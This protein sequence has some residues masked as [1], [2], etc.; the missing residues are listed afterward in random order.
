MICERRDTDCYG[1]TVAACRAGGEDL[2]AIMVR[3][4]YAWAFT[5]YSS[6]YVEQEARA[7]A[8]A[9]GQFGQREFQALADCAMVSRKFETSRRREVLSFTHHAEVAA[10]PSAEADALLDQ[11]ATWRAAAR[12][13]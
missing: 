13:S 9:E 3:G 10:L 7:K 5:R 11:A 8:A 4:V 1:R 6:D 2:G 12:S